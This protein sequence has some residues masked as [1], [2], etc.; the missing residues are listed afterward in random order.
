MK[1]GQYGIRCE[2]GS[3]NIKNSIVTESDLNETGNAGIRLFYPSSQ[4]ILQNCTI[5]H[6]KSVGLSL[7]G[8]TMPSLVNSIVYHNNS[9][10]PQLSANL[11]PDVVAQYSCIQHC[12][13]VNYNVNSDPEFVYFDP[14]IVY[15]G[16]NSPCKDAG[17]PSLDYTEQVD[18]AQRNRVL[19]SWVD[20]G[21]YEVDPDCQM[22]SNVWDWNHDGR[23]NLNEFSKFSTYW[24]AHDPNDPAITDPNHPDHTY[25]TEP[26]SPGYVSPDSLARWYPDGHTF[27]YITTGG[28]QY[29]I[30]LADVMVFAEE[31]PWLWC[32]CWLPDNEFLSGGGEMSM[33]S[34][35]FME[36]D[37]F[38]ILSEP[39]V[40]P[41]LSSENQITQLQQ[42]LILLARIWVEEPDIQQQIDAESWQE[43]MMTV[44]QNLLDLK[45]E[46]V[47]IQ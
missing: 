9:G 46:T 11:N 45:T 4:P 33:M 12:A 10:G 35:G 2:N 24:L 15:I 25:L 36:L 14:N 28:S 20:I 30:D 27:N 3:P 44:Y 42:M 37:G 7:V 38:Q 43:F 22:D 29:A 40:V 23:V 5:S 6:N 21:A 34:G 41:Q 8:S 39:V 13:E 31:S 18:M 16:Y 1:Q 17:S 32:A 19:G 26:N 47:P